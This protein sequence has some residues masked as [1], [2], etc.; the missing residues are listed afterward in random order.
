MKTIYTA[1]ATARGGREGHVRSSDG[2]LDMDLGSPGKVYGSLVRT[3]PEQL[4]AA[5]YSACFESA[6]SGAAR[7]Q[8]KEIGAT[9][10]TAQVA[11]NRTDDNKYALAVELRGRIEGVSREETA[12][13]MQAAHQICPYSHATR[14]NV[15]VKLFAEDAEKTVPA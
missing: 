2:I 9:S 1:V 13:L 8:K 5:A 3:N 7:E 14:G 10:I 6:L 12:A 4:F 11:L 15:E